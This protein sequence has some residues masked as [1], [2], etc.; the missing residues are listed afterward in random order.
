M[1]GT[2]TFGE[3]N[4]DLELVRRTTAHGILLRDGR[5][6]CVAIGFGD[7]I[8]DV[9]GGAIDGDETHHQALV[10]ECLEET[11]LEVTPGRFITDV[12]QYVVNRNNPRQQYLN[13]A[14]FFE[15]SLIGERLEAKIE[16]DHELVWLEPLE[17]IKRIRNDGY[18]WAI[19]KWLRI[20]AG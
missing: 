13:H 17:I 6:A 10:R 4:P 18:A 5:L 16:D 2:L 3:R 11:G 15:V 7:L 14:H 20:S 12:R 9:P 1:A 19:T 8:Y